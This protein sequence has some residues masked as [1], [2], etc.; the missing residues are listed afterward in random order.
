VPFTHRGT[1]WAP[2]LDKQKTSQHVPLADL[3]PGL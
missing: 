2:W 3:W 1:G